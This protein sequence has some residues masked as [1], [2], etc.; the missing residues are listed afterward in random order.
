[1]EHASRYPAE[2]PKTLGSAVTGREAEPMS[3]VQEYREALWSLSDAERTAYLDA[4]S[5]LPGPRGNL[6]LMQAAGDVGH[7]A[8][9]RE[10][11]GSDDEYRAAVGAAGLGGHLRG[12]RGATDPELASLLHRLATDPLWRVREGV[13]MALQRWG[14]RDPEAMFDLA[15]RWAEDTDPLVRRAAVAGVCEPRLLHDPSFAAAAVDICAA[16]T[17][18][19]CESPAPRGPA[20]RVLRQ[21]LGYCW[22]VAVAADPGP[23]MPRF[24]ALADDPDPDVAW[25]VRENAKK[26]R[27]RKLLPPDWS[28][29]RA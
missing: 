6:E 15:R 25:I 16:A 27:L 8:W 22:S 4:H 28:S 23:G 24:L 5:N 13:A 1:M 10:L 11:S 9:L 2:G 18:R 20:E 29:R 12:E 17:R 14:D 26:A 3:R 21:G 19:M 7:R